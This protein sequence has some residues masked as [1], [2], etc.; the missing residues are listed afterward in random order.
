MKFFVSLLSIFIF[1]TSFSYSTEINFPIEINLKRQSE[2]KGCGV[3]NAKYTLNQNNTFELLYICPKDKKKNTKDIGTWK[4]ISKNPKFFFNKISVTYKVNGKKYTDTIIL[5]EKSVQILWG[6]K[7]KDNYSYAGKVP[8][9]VKSET[10]KFK[11]NSPENNLISAYKEYLSIRNVNKNKYY[12]NASQMK[13]AKKLIKSIEN[14]YKKQI[15][16]NFDNLWSIAKKQYIG[17]LSSNIEILSSSYSKQGQNFFNLNMLAL[18]GS[19]DK[20][21]VSLSKTDKDF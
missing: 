14:E 7:H 9:I 11:K 13:N 10:V 1:F 3:S 15:K 12:G 5:K 6:N 4:N 17:E 19:A 2:L 21:N 20:V 18:K 8:D 16:Q